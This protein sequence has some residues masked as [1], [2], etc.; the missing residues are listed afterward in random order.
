MYLFHIDALAHP[1]EEFSHRLP[2]RNGLLLWRNLYDAV[3]G[4]TGVVLTE[5]IKTDH[6]ERWL[7]VHNIRA[8][9]Y[10]VIDPE[11]APVGQQIE[12]MMIKN[13]QRA[14]DMYVDVDA[15]RCAALLQRGISVMLLGD[16]YILRKEWNE[17]ALDRPSWDE[18]VEEMDRQAVLK[19]KKEWLEE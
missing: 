18:L 3:L 19:S 17:E 10:E 4:R 14:G 11:L 15:D 2:R 7:R 6:L 9:V 8:S 13:G 1:H 16:P 5:D 12:T